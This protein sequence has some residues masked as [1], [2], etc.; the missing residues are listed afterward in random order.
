MDIPIYIQ[1][2]SWKLSEGLTFEFVFFI[3][4]ILWLLQLILPL[5]VCKFSQKIGMPSK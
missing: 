2:W 3:Y 1:K 4:L 5:G